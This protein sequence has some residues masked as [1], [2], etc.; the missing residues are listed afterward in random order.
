MMAEAKGS[1]APITLILIH[2]VISR[3]LE[4]CIR[5]TRIYARDGYPDPETG[6]G[7]ALYLRTLTGVLYLHHS[8]ED[9]VAFPFLDE[10][11]PGYLPIDSL[12]T[13]HEQMEHY[14]EEMTPLL[15]KLHGEGG[16]SST[17]LAVLDILTK[18][19]E[20]WPGHIDIEETISLTKL[21][22]VAS[23]EE[24]TIWLQEMGQHRP[25][26]GPPDPLSMPFILYN[27]SAEDRAIM[28]QF[29]PPAVTEE[30]VPVVW[31][32]QWAPM[33]PFMLE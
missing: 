31:K 26:G 10:K 11:L 9:V 19:V 2:R 29:I 33:K 27:L 17:L 12:I 30:L 16:E 28:A 25:E 14:L 32:D 7:F 13:D 23:G 3:G 1:D 15:D 8:A 5:F 24:I 21:Q 6:A 20:I 22:T 4:E 18:L